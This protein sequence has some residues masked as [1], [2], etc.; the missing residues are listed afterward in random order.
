MSDP[1]PADSVSPDAPADG[2]VVQTHY[3][4]GRHVVLARARFSDL[5][6][7]YYL[8]LADNALKP[9]PA[10]DA[11][12]KDALAAF[13]LH[14][15]VRPKHEL[16]AW[17]LHFEDPRFNLFLI[18]DNDTGGLAGRTFDENVKQ[19]DGNSFYADVVRGTLPPQRSTVPFVGSDA[20][21]AVEAF[22]AAS[23][24]R[25]ARFFRLG[26][27]EFAMVGPHPDHDP[28]WLAALDAEA[29]RKLAETEDLGPLEKRR[30][31]WECGCS[32]KRILGVLAPTMKQSPE[33]L[34]GDDPSV[35]VRCPRCGGKYVITREAMEAFLADGGAQP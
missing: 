15:A 14:C 29:V 26:D 2:I 9:Q 18:G 13:A 5:Y 1:V 22:Y 19:M 7:D 16:I 34:F 25:L 32:E 21:V 35:L 20:L 24:Q 31:R 11:I 23:E 8:H 28:A 30:Y 6:L 10:H 17:T 3:V 33:A 12:F 27:E 4:R